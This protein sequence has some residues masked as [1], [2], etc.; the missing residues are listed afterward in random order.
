MYFLGLDPDMHS[1]GGAMVD[2][3]GRLLM[4]F[5]IRSEGGKEKAAVVAMLQKA[6]EF[7]GGSEVLAMAVENQELYLTGPSRTKNPRSIL[8]LAQVAGGLLGIM[9]SNQPSSQIYFPKPVEWKGSID[10][11]PHHR[12]ILAHAGIEPHRIK[13]M[14]G[15]DP[16]CSVSGF[17][18][19]NAGD[20]KHVTDAIGL[21]QYAAKQYKFQI[22]KTRFLQKGNPC[23]S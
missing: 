6:A 10:K 15:K 21:A 3:D 5:V 1:I 11:L 19:I 7:L 9:L 18:H 13:V 17:E 4:P 14:G 12:R 16:Y 23:P 2:A 20:W 22:D 8:H